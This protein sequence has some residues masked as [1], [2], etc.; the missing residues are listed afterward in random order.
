M[1]A[2]VFGISDFLFGKKSLPDER[3][4][5]LKEL[6]RSQKVTSIQVEFTTEKDLKTADAIVCLAEKN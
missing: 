2:S 4:N 5:T 3:L 6:Y 1:K